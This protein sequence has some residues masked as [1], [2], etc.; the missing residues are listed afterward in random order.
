VGPD[1]GRC[2]WSDPE[3][4]ECTGTAE[5]TCVAGVPCA[6]PGGVAR[7]VWRFD[8]RLRGVAR[9]APPGMGAHGSRE[10][11]VEAGALPDHPGVAIA[12]SD[13]DSRG[14]LTG[15]GALRV[16]V[17]SRVTGGAGSQATVRVSGIRHYPVLPAW[18]TRNGWDRFLYLA[19]APGVV[20]G[21]AGG[22]EPGRD[23]L[24]VT[25]RA[26]RVARNDVEALA[27]LAGAPQESPA[28]GCSPAQLCAYFEGENADDDDTFTAGPSGP[29]LNDRLRVLRPAS[30]AAR[31]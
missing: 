22:C 13:Y 8:L 10:V 9:F 19:L 6:L 21:G 18:H 4:A 14:R 5:E 25:D 12:V 31:P 3:T 2:V 23:C 30:R 17:P 20:P 29:G 24:V 7:R 1:A 15:A 11:S 27:L 16:G 26:G 28:S